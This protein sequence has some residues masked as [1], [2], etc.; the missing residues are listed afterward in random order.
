MFF[1]YRICRY[2]SANKRRYFGTYHI[3]LDRFP[4]ADINLD[5]LIYVETVTL[6]VSG[7]MALFF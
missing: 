1:G 6:L 2:V 3:S 5:L 4:M 7:K